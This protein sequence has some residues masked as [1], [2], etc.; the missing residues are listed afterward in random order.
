VTLTTLLLLSLI[1]STPPPS[2]LRIDVVL[3]GV[4]P[5]P[6]L[7][8]FAMRE[9]TLIW[10]AYDVDIRRVQAD[11]ATRADA[12]RLT[13][14]LA[15]APARNIS[16]KALGV[17][18]FVGDTP[19]PSILLYPNR[20]ATLVDRTAGA[21]SATMKMSPMLRDLFLGR[22]LGRAL[23]HEIGHYLLRSRAH[24]EHGLMR[25]QQLS[26]DLLLADRRGFGLSNAEIIR[27]RAVQA[28]SLAV[29]LNEQ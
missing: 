19:E 27:L 25:G 13:V 29:D 24:S 17:I 14:V 15:P 22:A 6:R 18:H 7:E 8:A 4:Q 16:T 2:P 5:S 26:C 10:R 12:I 28:S 23:A 9:A 1:G 21:D 3:S 11:D 20:A